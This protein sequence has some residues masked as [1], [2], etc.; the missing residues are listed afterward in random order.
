MKLE[1]AS[2]LIIASLL[3]LCFSILTS[4]QTP[5]SSP[6]TTIDSRGGNSV[7]V[8]KEEFFVERAIPL[9]NVHALGGFFGERFRKNKDIYLKQFPIQGYI[10]FVMKQDHTAWDWTQTEQH[11]KW[12]ESS[13]LAVAQSG[14]QELTKE[15]ENIFSQ[16]IAL[17]EPEGYLGPTAKAVRTTEK[18]DGEWTRT[19]CTMSFML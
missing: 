17:Q 4:A 16:F 9:K 6:K 14:D 5:S 8:T 10:S 2:T 18:P 7:P 13:V 19:N 11:G 12:I 1:T 3:V 15:V